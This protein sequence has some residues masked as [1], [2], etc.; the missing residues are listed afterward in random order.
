MNGESESDTTMP[1][2]GEP[3]VAPVSDAS[4][5]SLMAWIE[6]VLKALGAARF[7]WR[8]IG[9]LRRFLRARPLSSRRRS[10]RPFN[11]SRRVFDFRMRVEFGTVRRSSAHP[12]GEETQGGLGG[13]LP[14]TEVPGKIRPPS[15]RRPPPD[16]IA[17]EHHDPEGVVDSP[18]H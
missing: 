13:G 1:L 12:A 5:E 16:P 7:M 6:P 11:E 17:I 18:A 14:G 10:R 3:P 9:S 8:C 4:G 2:A 15:G